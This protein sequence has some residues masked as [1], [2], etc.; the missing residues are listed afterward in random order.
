MHING[1]TEIAASG[2]AARRADV[3]LRANSAAGVREARQ[4]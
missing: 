3:A 4:P 2:A 1:I